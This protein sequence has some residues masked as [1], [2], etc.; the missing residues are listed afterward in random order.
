MPPPIFTS[1]IFP[2]S[3]L[4]T[5]SGELRCLTSILDEGIDPP[6][7]LRIIRLVVCSSNATR[8]GSLASIRVGSGA[9]SVRH[10]LLR[11]D[12]KRTL[13]GGSGSPA[14][15]AGSDACEE[16]SWLWGLDHFH[17]VCLDHPRVESGICWC[18]AVA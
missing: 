6:L 16:G 13:R 7:P 8:L 14:S 12:R 9:R 1:S 17:C 2:F 10:L 11:L 5:S 3:N 4:R 15:L 18:W